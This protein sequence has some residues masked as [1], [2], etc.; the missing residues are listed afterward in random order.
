[1]ATG[2]TI[3]AQGSNEFTLE[4][5]LPKELKE[6]SGVAKDGNALWAIADNSKNTMYKLDL[7]GNI[8]K[9][10]VINNVNF[11]NAEAITSDHHYVYIGDVGD[12]NG[13]RPFRSI[14]RILKTDLDNNKN[15]RGEE[16]RFTFPDEGFIKKKKQNNFDCEA[17][18]SYRD[19]IYLFSKRRDD[20]RTELYALPKLPG[21]YVARSIGKF[22]VKGLITDADVNPEGNEVAII[23]YEEGHTRPFIYIFSNFKGDHFFSGNYKRYE[24]A[25]NKKIDWQVESIAYADDNSF[26]LS[27]EKTAD[28]PNT[29]YR[30]NKSD[31]VLSSKD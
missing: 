21:S 24:L 14:F 26:F 28:V 7:T 25:S 1:M 4:K 23:G 27:C 5:Q 18:M 29:L 16:I 17:I 9:K 11:I 12:N 6:V 15:I 8:S 30:I 3:Y 31:L 19:S 20:G 2:S 22:K 13:T 10:I